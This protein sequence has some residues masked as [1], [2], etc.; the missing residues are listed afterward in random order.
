MVNSC[1]AAKRRG[2]YPTLSPTI[3]PPLFPAVTMTVV[4][5][6]KIRTA[7]RIN[8][9]AGFVT[10][11]SWKKITL[12]KILR[13]PKT[14]SEYNSSITKEHEQETL[15]GYNSFNNLISYKLLYLNTY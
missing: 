9:I 8:Q 11:P 13:G 15:N 5:Y 6:R 3:L 10:L 7:L 14:M 4:R 12:F 2:K 1:R